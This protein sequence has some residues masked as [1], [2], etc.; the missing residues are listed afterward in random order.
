[1]TT[2][3]GPRYD[4][5]AEAIRSLP[6]AVE[7]CEAAG[8]PVIVEWP[9]PPPMPDHV[10]RLYATLGVLVRFVPPTD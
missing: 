4:A 7:A 6:D 9:T 1:M 8:L 3:G 2:E 5:R 10:Q